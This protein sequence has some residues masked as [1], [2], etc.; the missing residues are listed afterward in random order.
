MISFEEARKK[1]AE[2]IPLKGTERVR[3]QQTIN[4]VLAEDIFS[5]INM[6]PFDKSA[7]DGYACRRAD[8]Q[9]PLQLLEVIAAGSVPK[10]SIEEGYCSKIMTGAMLPPGADCVV[11]VEQAIQTED[12]IVTFTDARTK[13]NIAL[14][15]EDVSEGNKVLNKGTRIKAQHIAVLA[16][17]G[18]VKP[19]VYERAKVVVFSTGDELTEPENK[20]GNGKIRNSNSSQLIEQIRSTGAD[21]SYGGIIPDEPETTYKMITNAVSGND[22]VIL[23]GGISMGD[24]DYIPELLTSLGFEISFRSIAVQPG[25]PS[26][27]ARSHN[28]F[29]LGLPGNPVSSFNIFELLGKPFLYRLMGH[30]FEVPLVRMPLAETYTRKAINR[31]AFVPATINKEG[32]VCP[33]SYHGSAH[34]NALTDA[35]VLFSVPLGIERIAEGDLVDV[36][37]I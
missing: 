13:N 15:G 6:P 2:N 22:L 7:V 23:S 33:V 19:L 12:G 10:F 21:V 9:K 25:K 28:C 14:M 24:F 1:M 27:F 20:P 3:F 8:L 26:V 37:F 17:V 16:A 11:M 29:I 4:R 36:R 32:K 5:D 18:A 34:I 30:H 31:L 35:Q